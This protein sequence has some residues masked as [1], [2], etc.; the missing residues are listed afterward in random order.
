[1]M[2]ILH[3][4]QPASLPKQMPDEMPA[5]DSSNGAIIISKLHDVGLINFRCAD[6]LK[7][8]LKRVFHLSAP[9]VPNSMISRGMRRV[10][11][12]GPDEM[13]LIFEQQKEAELCRLFEEVYQGKHYAATVISDA[14]QLYYLEGI[15]T[16]NLL[17]KGCAL[18]L[19]KSVFAQGQC[20]Q[21]L[22]AH[23]GLTLACEA[24]DKF[25]LICRASFSNYVETWLKDASIE[26]GY[27]MK[28]SAGLG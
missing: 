23:A 6:D 7:D 24:E 20:A 12:L 1:M 15:E 11:W 4:S 8:Q 22:L 3:D 14:L 21:S 18:D 26:Y 2:D 28:E 5:P 19:H 13:L 25:L 17:A 10:L 27:M 16:R 9:T